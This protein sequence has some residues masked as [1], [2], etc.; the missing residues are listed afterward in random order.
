MDTQELIAQMILLLEDPA[1]TRYFQEQSYLLARALKGL[2]DPRV[3][4][5]V[6]LLAGYVDAARRWQKSLATVDWQQE[7]TESDSK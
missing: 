4:I 5:A 1:A 2:E 3:L 6:G 7:P